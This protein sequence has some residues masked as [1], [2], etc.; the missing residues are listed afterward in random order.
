[1]TTTPNPAPGSNSL[2]VPEN[3]PK[4]SLTIGTSATSQEPTSP[5]LPS[6]ISSPASED[7][8]S[9]SP[10][11]DGQRTKKHGQAAAR[12]HRSASPEKNASALAAARKETYCR[13]LSAPEF[14]YAVNAGTNGLPIAATSGPSSAASSRSAALQQFL[15]SKLRARMAA[16]GLMEYE[17]RW[18]CW[19]MDL[20]APICALRA[21]TRHTSASDCSGWRSPQAENGAS[22][23]L[24]L[25]AMHKKSILTL[26]AQ[27]KM[28]GW[29]TP[30]GGPDLEEV[31]GWS[32]PTVQD[33]KNNASPSQTRRNTAALNVQVALAGWASPH[34]PQPH[35]SDN[36][37][38]SYMRV[39][40]PG[41]ILT[42]FLAAT[43]NRGALNPAHSRWLMGF[44]AAWDSCGAMAMQSSRK[45]PPNS[46]HQ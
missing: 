23:A 33:A 42:S 18:K 11:P 13:I 32:T 31:A 43:A 39:Q 28:A 10:S 41:V 1:M 38:T 44:P 12:V 8:R 16:S 24:S 27:A 19:T 40:M 37:N 17:L 35:D 22:G 36:S 14:S 21:S 34:T 46:L 26:Q 30:K 29:P 2:S 6:A 3:S 5:V 9:L 4:A 15:E 45:S 7:G 20:G 25:E